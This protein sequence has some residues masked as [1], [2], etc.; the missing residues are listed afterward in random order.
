MKI[1]I[2]ARFGEFVETL[3][4]RLQI[5]DEVRR[6]AHAAILTRIFL[7]SR[8]DVRSQ[9]L[10]RCTFDDVAVIE[11][12]RHDQTSVFMAGG[13][14]LRTLIPYRSQDEVRKLRV[15]TVPLEKLL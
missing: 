4:G 8:V 15:R 5:G 10:Q 13:I 9:F 7:H 2:L 14:V 6:D 12:R 11:A 1:K 3:D